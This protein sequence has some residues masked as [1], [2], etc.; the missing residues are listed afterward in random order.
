MRGKLN[1]EKTTIFALSKTLGAGRHH[2]RSLSS[3]RC[4]R[5]LDIRTFAQTSSSLLYS[6]RFR[7]PK[8]LSSL[9]FS[10]SLSSSRDIRVSRGQ[11]ETER[12]AHLQLRPSTL[13]SNL[14]RHFS[15]HAIYRSPLP[16]QLVV[17]A[18]DL[19]FPS[20]K[21]RTCSLTLPSWSRKSASR[22]ENGGS[23]GFLHA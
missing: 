23:R 5:S 4:S 14:R 22:R 20:R 15:V 17:T 16:V 18:A 2:S 10:L 7:S 6:A 3:T 13:R 1:G 11:S 9:S 19:A 8:N 12:A 21:N